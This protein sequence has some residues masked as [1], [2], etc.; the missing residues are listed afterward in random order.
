M[1]RHSDIRIF[2]G[3][4]FPLTTLRD[5]AQFIKL[6]SDPNDKLNEPG[7]SFSITFNSQVFQVTQTSKEKIL[8]GDDNLFQLQ[9][10]NKAISEFIML[11]DKHGDIP[12]TDLFF[13][14]GTYPETLYF[15]D[16][17]KAI[18][19]A[20]LYASAMK[21]VYNW[22]RFGSDNPIYVNHY[23]AQKLIASAVI[24]TIG[25]VNGEPVV[26]F[27]II[28]ND[29]I[30]HSAK[31]HLPFLIKTETT[32]NKHAPKITCLNEVKTLINQVQS[33]NP[34]VTTINMIEKVANALLAHQDNTG[35]T[36]VTLQT[37]DPT[38]KLIGV[39]TPNLGGVRFIETYIDGRN[40][41]P[42]NHDPITIGSL[43]GGLSLLRREYGDDYPEIAQVNPVTIPITADCFTDTFFIGKKIYQDILGYIKSRTRKGQYTIS[44]FDEKGIKVRYV[45]WMNG[46]PYYSIECA[47]KGN[48]FIF[49]QYFTLNEIIQEASKEETVLL[50][51]AH[52]SVMSRIKRAFTNIFA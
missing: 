26:N 6:L 14:K 30:I 25:Y 44:H 9:D 46:K 32:V 19:N 49:D 3:K 10:L 51:I 48:I 4:T 22:Y 11:L 16:T 41:K 35:E 1:A 24:D 39:N 2:L 40:V 23:A 17:S 5:N 50:E 37:A 13:K 36:Y 43:I 20:K 29:E 15:T 42:L 47:D 38:V 45:S 27:N 52:K 21:R 8:V 33:A 18:L 7:T 31:I 12:Y 28:Q 34:K